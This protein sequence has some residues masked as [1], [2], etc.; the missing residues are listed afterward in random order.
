MSKSGPKSKA[1]DKKSR[2]KPERDL[3]ESAG[4]L[5][6]NAVCIFIVLALICFAIGHPGLGWCFLILS[7]VPVILFLIFHVM[8]TVFFTK[9]MKDIPRR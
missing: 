2:S 1:R 9:I 3:Y 7:V 8:T 6:T 4:G 5:L